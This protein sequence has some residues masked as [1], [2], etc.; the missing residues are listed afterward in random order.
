MNLSPSPLLKR[1]REKW[2]RFELLLPRLWDDEISL[3]FGTADCA[4]PDESAVR[5]AFI[6]VLFPHEKAVGRETSGENRDVSA[7]FSARADRSTQGDMTFPKHALVVD[8]EG[9]L[10]PRFGKEDPHHVH[11]QAAVGQP[12]DSRA[13]VDRIDC[14]L[15]L[16]RTG[17][18]FTSQEGR[19]R[20]VVSQ[21]TALARGEVPKQKR[22]NVG[23]E[24]H[25]RRLHLLPFRR[26]KHDGD[27]EENP[28]A[29]SHATPFGQVNCQHAIVRQQFTIHYIFEK[30]KCCT[31]DFRD[32]SIVLEQKIPIQGV[33]FL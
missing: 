17:E 1:M 11:A 32:Y 25:R 15:N 10:N 24:N 4:A 23:T 6:R 18:A 3:C 14:T 5:T 26:G 12:R 7:L 9:A 20:R 19:V 2:G 21:I 16:D 29:R 31:A 30:S 33:L 8:P 13:A 22:V 27:K 28:I